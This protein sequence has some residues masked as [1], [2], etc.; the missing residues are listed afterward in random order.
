M[1][2]SFT[3]ITQLDLKSR[4]IVDMRRT[5][6]VCTD[7]GLG[8]IFLIIFVFRRGRLFFLFFFL[9]LFFFI[10]GLLIGRLRGGF[11]FFLFFLIIVTTL[12]G[13]RIDERFRPLLGAL[14]F[15]IVV[16]IIIIF[17][18]RRRGIA[19][20][21]IQYVVGIFITVFARFLIQYI[22]KLIKCPLSNFVE[23]VVKPYNE[24][25]FEA[26]NV[27]TVHELRQNVTS[28]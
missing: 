28:L 4:L 1:R 10:I 17:K 2:F 25:V 22:L 24:L 11:F 21:I 15:F 8:C 3:A 23:L 20:I 5:A 26:R 27:V 16:F 14:V 6:R 9:F 12:F 18:R 19:L 13:L 7:I